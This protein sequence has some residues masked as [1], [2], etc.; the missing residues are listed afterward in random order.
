MRS[1]TLVEL[2]EIVL[3]RR[4]AA[5][6][7]LIAF[8][9]VAECKELFSIAKLRVHTRGRLRKSTEDV[10]NDVQALILLH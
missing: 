6:R 9:K 3:E 4:E 2:V 8:E 1:I 5:L 7:D 10:R